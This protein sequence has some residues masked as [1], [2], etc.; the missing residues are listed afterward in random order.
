MLPLCALH[1]VQA[2][3]RSDLVSPSV[4]WE[5]NQAQHSSAAN[6]RK[7]HAR[8]RVH[9]WESFTQRA[10]PPLTAFLLPPLLPPAEGGGLLHP[11]IWP[12]GHRAPAQLWVLSQW[13]NPDP[14]LLRP[15]PISWGRGKSE[16]TLTHRSTV[17]KA[18]VL[19]PACGRG[20]SAASDLAGVG[21]ARQAPEQGPHPGSAPAPPGPSATLRGSGPSFPCM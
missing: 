1:L 19:A 15:G 11:H 4:Q 3:E 12:S 5:W 13:R 16:V 18:G 17:P 9:A 14:V 6:S 20:G 21:W 7:T 8:T 2:T 10:A